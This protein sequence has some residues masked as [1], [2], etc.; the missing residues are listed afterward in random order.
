MIELLG[1]TKA[2]ELGLEVSQHLPVL[3][4]LCITFHSRGY[5]DEE[6]V[7]DPLRL[8]TPQIVMETQEKIGLC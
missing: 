8:T 5:A 3:I 6:I 7:A 4:F 1:F 2:A